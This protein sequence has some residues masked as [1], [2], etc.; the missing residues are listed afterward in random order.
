MMK[1]L[2]CLTG[3][4]STRVLKRGGEKGF[5]M[6]QCHLVRKENESLTTIIKIANLLYELVIACN[7]PV[8]RRIYGKECTYKRNLIHSFATE[9][10]SAATDAE[11]YCIT[12]PLSQADQQIVKD[13]RYRGQK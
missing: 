4:R 6:A 11:T 5:S 1:D 8:I 9:L 3:F 12:S 2:I 13:L 7:R 10:N